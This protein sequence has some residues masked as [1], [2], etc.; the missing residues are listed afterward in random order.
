MYLQFKLDVHETLLKVYTV[1]LHVNGSCL[2]NC[3]SKY[4][5]IYTLK[6]SNVSCNLQSHFYQKTS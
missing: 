6:E 4:W 5:F 2:L 1:T 3:F